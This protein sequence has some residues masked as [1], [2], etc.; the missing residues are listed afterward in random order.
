[1]WIMSRGGWFIRSVLIAVRDLDRS[2]EFYRD[3]MNLE[4]LT[5]EGEIAIL[6][7]DTPETSALILREAERHAIRHGQQALG[8]RVVSF[9]LATK[10]DLD[11]VEERLRAFGTLLTRQLVGGEQIEI[12][13]GHDPDGLP[14]VFLTFDGFDVL[15]KDHYRHVAMNMYGLDI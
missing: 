1:M 14:L 9:N 6:G 3:V 12:V 13:R 15:P 11:H 8:A 5:R 10:A 7:M 2:V 4:E